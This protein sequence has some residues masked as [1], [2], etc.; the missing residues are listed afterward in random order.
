MV[1][2]S[3]YFIVATR[4]LPWFP[5]YQEA[6]RG[7]CVKKKQGVLPHIDGCFGT[8]TI[9]GPEF[10]IKESRLAQLV[11]WALVSDLSGPRAAP[12]CARRDSFGFLLHSRTCLQA[13][14]ISLI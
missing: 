10:S 13:V 2:V 5:F 12:P 8:T 7:T 3:I 4:D 9:L 6:C 1:S 14:A 11:V